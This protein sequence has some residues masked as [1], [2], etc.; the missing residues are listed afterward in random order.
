M[1][2][3]RVHYL[4]RHAEWLFQ[5]R[6][7]GSSVEQYEELQLSVDP[8]TTIRFIN[9]GSYV[10]IANHKVFPIMIQWLKCWFTAT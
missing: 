4:E 1:A 5:L 8:I 7:K 2:I 3:K 6:V 10:A 9:N